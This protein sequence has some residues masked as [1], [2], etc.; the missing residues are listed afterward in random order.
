MRKLLVAGFVDVKV[1]P[2]NSVIQ[3]EAAQFLGVSF[4]VSSSSFFLP[5][6]EWMDSLSPSLYLNVQQHVLFLSFPGPSAV[7]VFLPSI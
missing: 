2:V 6:K 4:L 7:F 1:F 3:S 5:K